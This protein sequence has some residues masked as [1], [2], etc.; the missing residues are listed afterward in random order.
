MFLLTVVSCSQALSPTGTHQVSDGAVQT[1]G[2]DAGRQVSN[3][4]NQSMNSDA[5]PL[6]GEMYQRISASDTYVCALMQSQVGCWGTRRLY[7]S[8]LP[9]QELL[10]FAQGTT[11]VHVTVGVNHGCALLSDGHVAC[12]G[13]N[14]FGQLG[15]GEQNADESRPIQATAVTGA[16]FDVS[17]GESA[18]CA[19]AADRTLQCWGWN[20]FD[21]LG[22]KNNQ[23]A[24]ILSPMR[25]ADVGNNVVAFDLSKEAASSMS[26]AISHQTVQ[27]YGRRTGGT[28][29]ELGIAEGLVSPIQVK[30]GIGHACALEASGTLKCWGYNSHGQIGDGTTKSTEKPVAVLEHVVSLGLGRNHTC[31]VTLGGLLYC[32]GDNAHGAVGN[33]MTSAFEAKPSLVQ[34]LSDVRQ[35]TAAGEFTCAQTAD[36]KIWCWGRNDSG[37]LGVASQ[38]EPLRAG[39]TQPLMFAPTP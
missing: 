32:W 1:T 29:Q 16:V 18:T 31:A 30:V 26:C 5:G 37:Q 12:W 25:P 9:Y 3:D 15:T 14:D 36:S 21:Q 6:D 13:D 39:P 28:L 2:N 10:S 22:T 4:A 35:V 8:I 24:A 38:V 33:G 27:C 7:G 20:G 23:N 17:A 34:K 11:P 19:I